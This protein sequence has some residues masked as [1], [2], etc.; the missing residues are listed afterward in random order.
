MTELLLRYFRKKQK[1]VQTEKIYDTQCPFC[2]MQCKMQ[3]IEQST[4]TRK[5]YQ[6][7]AK[8]NPTSQGRLCIKGLH[9][10][11][12]A[13]HKDRI[14]NPLLNVDGEFQEIS[15]EHAIALI[16]EK[17]TGI[18]SSYGKN[19]LSVY[20]SATITN[21]EAY[22][23]GKFARVALQ[24]KY[25]DY[26]GR[27]CMSSAASAAVQTFGMDRGFTNSIRD[28]E[29]TRCIILAGTNIAECQPTMMPYFERA[30]EK[31]CFII[32]IDP[33]ETMTTKLAD[34]HLKVK[35]GM[36][37]AL[38]NGIL[39]VIIEKGLIDH[40]FI[41]QR[42]AGFDEVKSHV[43]SLDLEEIA[44][45]TGV[46]SKLIEQAATVFGKEETGMIFTARGVEQQT[47]GSISVRNFLNILLATGKVGKAYSGFGAVTGQGNGQGAREHGQKAD[48]LPG[49]RSIENQEHREYV[50]NL[51]GVKEKDLPRK[52]V[53]AFEMFEKMNEGEIKGLFL[54]CSNP[55][56]SNPSSAFVKQAIEKL[57]FFV[58]VDMFISETASLADL[59]LPATSYLETSGT[60]TNVE[61]RV[62]L[63]EASFPLKANAKHDWQIICEVAQALGYGDYFSYHTSEEIFEEL[64]KV[65]KGGLA[66]YSGITY[67]RLRK[68]NG[69]L[70]PC[71]DELHPGTERLFE[72]RFAH[73]DGK[74]KMIPVP[75]KAEV[76][77]ETPSEDF[78]LYLTTG[79]VMSHY[80]TG[81]QTRK[82]SSLAA[83]EF[84][85]FMEIHPE[86]AREY[87]INDQA[88][89][90]IESER[91]S[92]IVR[93]RLSASIRK[94]T[95]FVPFH[96]EET[97][98]VNQLISKKLDPTCRMPGF[99]VSAVRIRS[100]TN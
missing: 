26:N 4:V 70:W 35:P 61:G 15:W 44:R 43:A 40:S 84:E 36:D 67:D 56:V 37:A 33:R 73:S 42:V 6:T 52:G 12:H 48:Q 13:L 49:Y 53:S 46:E 27:L 81:V 93:S 87:K 66:D 76:K 89:V 22:L 92:I 54:M 18:Q 8:D 31:G 21:E 38:A 24:T 83:R 69:I 97:Q 90:E 14:R 94:D 64:R 23:L 39:K 63:R 50:A 77:K 55:I 74:A 85:S 47:D 59:I 65:S 7:I 20:G 80:L 25:I 60:M 91:G 17:F 79:R 9:A 78:P 100:V 30:K 86:T 72:E 62:T 82:S 3:L 98:N 58:A 5:K 88:L 1:E 11:Q 34:I 99:K 95:L 41:E 68:E 19:A 29:G 10:H 28:I 71:T 45:L 16:K 32:A 51:W 75:N 2:S 57:D 96:W